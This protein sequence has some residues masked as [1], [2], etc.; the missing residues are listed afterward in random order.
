MSGEF[1]AVFERDGEWVVALC[2]EV[3]GA[4]GQGRTEA[5]ASASLASAIRLIL[6]DG[7]NPARRAA[8]S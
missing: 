5:E 1:A 7:R 2:L 3:P 4:N 6:E 8:R